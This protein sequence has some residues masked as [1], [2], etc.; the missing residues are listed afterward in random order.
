MDPIDTLKLNGEITLERTGKGIFCDHILPIPK[1][2]E[3]IVCN[4]EH[5]R[6]TLPCGTKMWIKVIKILN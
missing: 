3:N 4:D 6:M 5:I 1:H 2:S